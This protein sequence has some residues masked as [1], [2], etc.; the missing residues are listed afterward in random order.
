MPNTKSSTCRERETQQRAP[1][2]SDTKRSL[3]RHGEKESVLYYDFTRGVSVGSKSEAKRVS[4]LPGQKQ[5]PYSDFSE[6]FIKA[7]LETDIRA[8]FLLLFKL[9]YKKR[10]S[11]EVE[12]GLLC[13]IWKS[14]LALSGWVT[15]TRQRPPGGTGRCEF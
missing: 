7:E 12:I 8:T 9:L 6:K 1:R 10:G 2:V 13:Q 15:V 5:D 14:S 3:F 11:L 4:Q